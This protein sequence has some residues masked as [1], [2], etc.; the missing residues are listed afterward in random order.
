MFRQATHRNYVSNVKIKDKV[1]IITG[2]NT[3][4]GYATAE[5]LAMRGAKVIL[6]C[7]NPQRGLAARDKIIQSTGN[8]K[9]IF[10]QLDLSSFKSVRDFADDILKSES[11]LDIL[12][13][14]AGIL[15]VGNYLTAD[16]LPIEAQVNHFSPFLLTMLLLPLLKSS[17]PSRIINV[18][19]IF[20]IFGNVD[21]LDKQTKSSILGRYV[22]RVYSNTK[23]ANILFTRKLSEHLKSTRVT[24]N[25]LHPGAVST[26]LFRN[27]RFTDLWF[28]WFINLTANQGAQTSIYLAIDPSLDSVS[29]KYF[30]NCREVTPIKKARDDNAAERLWSL[31]EDIVFSKNKEL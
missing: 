22:E 6:A 19:S 3:G 28:S 15:N 29:G 18:S 17:A 20:Y 13:N 31:S 30:S 27:R 9:I 23:L 5:D 24:A 10:K 21:N 26:D 1:V 14:N 11:R 7:R 12:I 8:K 2:S 25:C 4:V 16:K